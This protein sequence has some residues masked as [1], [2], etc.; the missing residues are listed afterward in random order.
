MS[1]DSRKLPMIALRGTTVLPG[2]AANIDITRDRSIRAVDIAAAGDGLLFLIPQQDTELADPG[3]DDLY[4]IGTIAKLK[5]ITRS[6]RKGY[7]ISAEGLE[8]AAL[9]DM[10][11]KDGALY[12]DAALCPDEE[13]DQTHT[14]QYAMKRALQDIYRDYAAQF[15]A[16]WRTGETEDFENRSLGDL[17]NGIAAKARFEFRD[18][19]ALLEALRIEDRYEVLCTLLIR[20][21]QAQRIRNDL[22]QRVRQKIEKGQKEYVLREQ[23]K[24]IL[25][26]LGE[27]S[28]VSEA[29]EYREKLEALDAPEEVKAGIS[30]EIERFRS[31]GG[32]TAESAVVREYLD[33]VMDLPWNRM[34]GD[35]IDLKRAKKILDEDH[36]GLEKVKERALEFL[37]VRMLTGNGESPVLCL[38]GPPGTGKTSVAKSLAR[39][40]DRRFVRISL[41]GVHDEA[42][43][44]GHRRTYVGAL[45]GRIVDG[46]RK[47]GVKNPVML[48]DEI[49]KPGSDNRGD[50]LNALL[51]VLDQEQNSRFRDHYIDLPVDLSQVM[52]VATANSVSD[53]PRPLADRMEIIEI[54]GYTENEKM[55]IAREHLIGRQMERNGLAAGQLTIT[56]GALEHIITGYT[57]EA[58]VRQLE[59]CIGQICRRTARLILEDGEEKVKVRAADLPSFLGRE[60]WRQPGKNPGGERGIACG[61]AWTAVGGDTLRIE[62]N[63]MPGKG[64]LL[65]TGRLGDVMKES[66][67][68]GISWMRSESRALG[69]P[70]DYFSVTDIHIHIPEGAV[71]KDGPSA[72]IT[73]A[74]AMVSAVTGRKVRADTAMTGEITLRGR[75]LPVGGLKEKLLAAGMAGI[76]NVIVPEQNRPD[77]EELSEEITGRLKVH[78]VRDMDQVLA[79]ALEPPQG[80]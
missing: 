67:M 1:S 20:E 74:S 5:R 48:L 34:S 12:A 59:R 76:E 33:T 21:T 2:A 50:T 46:L 38:A 37:A 57:K 63:C 10:E 3:V 32:S 7:V 11:E 39:A 79:L 42:E 45:P 14:A 71:P 36:Y 29:E 13:P 31:L 69:I 18:R 55:H 66:A 51:E 24:E 27:T 43:I 28:P 4:R 56:R 58:G 65:L 15:K 52:F 73:M 41:G 26:E 16:P 22:Q 68:A 72:G 35:S 8:R 70:E 49:D 64:E 9:M 53:I 44:R 30:K 19:Q 78:Y 61:L 40:M 25:E 17:V 60:K 54:G 80:G 47:A 77:V 23:L 6:P 75:V 62:V